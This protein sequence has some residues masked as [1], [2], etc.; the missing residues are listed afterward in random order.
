[1]AGRNELVMCATTEIGFC[2]STLKKQQGRYCCAYACNAKPVKKLGGLCY[3]H[4]RRKRRSLDSI[5]ERYSQWLSKCRQRKIPNT[6]TLIQFREFC[7]RTGYLITK[8]KRG[9]N[10]TIDRPENWRGYS[11]DNMQLLTGRQNIRK[12]YDHDRY[13]QVPD[14]WVPPEYV[15]GPEIEIEEDELP[16]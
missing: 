6:V 16:F 12:Y 14:D 9:Q 1:M 8:G 11:V 5:A 10:A 7:Q 13:E 2:I 4:Y 3:T 15:A